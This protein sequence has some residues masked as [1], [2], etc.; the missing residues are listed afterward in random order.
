MGRHKR[1]RIRLVTDNHLNRGEVGLANATEVT[2][3]SSAGPSLRL[4]HSTWAFKRDP[5]RFS[6]SSARLQCKN[7]Y[8]RYYHTSWSADKRT[9]ITKQLVRT[10]LT[11]WSGVMT[12]LYDC[13]M[14][15][16]NRK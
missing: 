6:S 12:C 9:D 3:Y 13:D 2:E 14:A 7:T 16:E 11:P 5:P 10:F 8:Y 1:H 15:P 4:R